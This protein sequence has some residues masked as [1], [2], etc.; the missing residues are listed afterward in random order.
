[1]RI[2][3]A[4]LLLT[5][6]TAP[7]L[8]AGT[9]TPVGSTAQPI[10]IVDHDVRV[11]ITNGFARTEVEQ[12]F[13]NPN[14]TDLEAVYETPL[15]ERA[16]LSEMTVILTDGEREQVLA[17]EV[18]PRDQAGDLYQKEKSKGRDA[19]LADKDGWRSYRFTVSP[20]RAGSD[21]RVRFVYYQPLAVDT[22]VGRYVYPL[23]EGGTDDRAA[24][25]FWTRR[26]KVDG[27]L[28]FEVDLRSAVP[29]DEV[30]TPGL[31]AATATK[32][33]APGHFNV[34]TELADAA[35]NRD[36]VLYYRLADDLPGRLQV[37]AHRDDPRKPGTFMAV[38]TP[39]LDLKPLS[40]GADYVFV[41]D[42]SGSMDAKI[43]T[44]TDAVGHTLGKMRPEDR[45]RVVTFNTSARDLL[46]GWRAAT[47]E[48]VTD[49]LNKVRA[50]RADGSTNL[51]DGLRVAFDDLDDDR[52]TSVVLLTDAVANEGIVDPEQF[53]DLAAQHD[54]RIFG[55]LLGSSGNWPLMDAIADASGGFYS[56]VSNADDVVGQVLLAKS[57]VT[58]E[59][60][61][62]AHL[63]IAGVGA[64]ELTGATREAGRIGKVFR[65]QQLVVF[66]RYTKPGAATFR[67]KA[68]LTGQDR[69]YETT[70]DLPETDA[71]WPEL[72]RMWALAR[73]ES[74]EAR[75]D[76][77]AMRE[78]EAATALRDL[79]VAY[80]IVTDETSMVVMSDAAFAEHGVERRN[81][82]R[83][84]REAAARQ[85]RAADPVVAQP[86]TDQKKRMFQR[87]APRLG[88]GG[89]VDPFTA[90][91][92]VLLI[93][94]AAT[95]RRR[96]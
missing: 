50:L 52:A 59:S 58:H 6:T 31:E 78:G 37:I 86:R 40:R 2:A 24:S 10:Q 80:Q 17:G 26:E 65:G 15:P 90:G 21:T 57:K 54:L 34:R 51:Y 83:T 77:G 81:Q 87:R 85:A 30:R 8:A 35:L 23:E 48:A 39:G 89:A 29:I 7:A 79:G 82:A 69:T 88:G 43:G 56:R 76:R 38:L 20:V 63:E 94:I 71:N 60:L 73:A 22:G 44:L 28:S 92:A 53:A 93:G 96:G 12:V 14:A 27:R 16:A 66:G 45:F 64:R 11:S 9:L 68:R 55:F 49:A 42:V 62:D 84:A 41:L 1:M 91:L 13:R 3:L 4:F 74:I 18:L 47:P 32:Q 72:E 5:L 25:A 33:L 36:F 70:I 61:H 67:L 46:G 95:R 19:G 75:R